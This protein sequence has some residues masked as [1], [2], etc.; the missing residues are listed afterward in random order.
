MRLYCGSAYVCAQQ[1]AYFNLL[2]MRLVIFA[3]LNWVP[4]ISNIDTHKE[5]TGEGF[6]LLWLG[7][8]I[9]MLGER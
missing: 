4:K 2:Q 8:V 5:A 3:H 9:D 7:R 1:V 6:A